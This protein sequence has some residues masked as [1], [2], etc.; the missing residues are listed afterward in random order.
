MDQ[1]V[2]SGVIVRRGTPAD[3]AALAAFAARTFEET[4]AH[5]TSVADMQAHLA[6][7]YGVVQ[8]GQELADPG[9]TT[10][11]M[12]RDGTMVGFAQVRMA[13]P[14]LE[15]GLEA[16]VE[17]Y[18]FY[19]DRAWHGR[20]LAGR[21]MSEV[22]RVARELAGRTLWLS[23]WEENERAKGFYRKAGFEDRGRIDFWLG[24]DKQT[25]C[26]YVAPVSGDAP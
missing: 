22:H 10:V 1:S 26:L 25:D 8:Q 18:R 19:L 15:L 6:R 21:L 9:M 24:N 4:F 12:E 17:V 16:P 14:E 7:S 3:A 20:G 2:L 13:A 23:V 5:S 11:L